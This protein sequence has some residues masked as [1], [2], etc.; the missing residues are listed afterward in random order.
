MRHS[1]VILLT[2]TLTLPA[3]FAQEQPVATTTPKLIQVQTEWIELPRDV[4]ARLLLQRSATTAD[5]TGLRKEV[6]AMVQA[7]TAKLVDLQL[8]TSRSGERATLESHHEL[9]YPTEAEP[10]TVPN[11]IG[12]LPKF[13]RPKVD[14]FQAVVGLIA[15]R[16]P[17]SFATRNVGS[18]FEMRATASESSQ[19]IDLSLFPSLTW[20]PENTV[21]HE[22]TDIGGG[23]VK[24]ERPGFYRLQPQT[25]LTL[26]SGACSLAAI[27]TP[28]GQNGRAD[29][30]RE[31]MLFVKATILTAK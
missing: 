9:I 11:S 4:L 2:L 15:P 29:F 21:W 24:I 16:V 26:K 27:L 7:G 5:A 30:D 1:L 20:H 8:L 3:L 25:A 31:V 14:N 22:R 18:A 23:L 13:E 19:I 10:P 28:H 17:E 6:Q 12:P